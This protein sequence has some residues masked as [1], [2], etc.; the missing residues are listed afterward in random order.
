MLREL[1]QTQEVRHAVAWAMGTL[2][3]YVSMARSKS[4]GCRI[5]PDC[6]PFSPRMLMTL[7]DFTFTPV[8]ALLVG[9]QLRQNL[10]ANLV[11]HLG[12]RASAVFEIQND[13]MDA[14]RLKRFEKLQHDFFAR[15]GGP[16]ES[17][18]GRIGL[19]TQIDVKRLGKRLEDRGAG[20][21]HSG[22]PLRGH[23]GLLRDRPRNVIHPS[24]W[25][26]IH[27]SVCWLP[28]VTMIGNWPT[29]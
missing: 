13:V 12:G 10:F 27:S 21:C 18:R 23:F 5:S 20:G 16:G 7:T 1:E 14:D 26:A 24:E 3:S 9:T 8:R 11:E 22:P 28:P 15:R 17:A 4:E 25:A 29:A 19:R 6:R 2:P